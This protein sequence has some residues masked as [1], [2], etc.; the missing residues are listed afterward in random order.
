MSKLKKI[1][2]LIQKAA[3]VVAV[4]VTAD[5]AVKI[6]FAASD[7]SSYSDDRSL[8]VIALTILTLYLYKKNEP[9]NS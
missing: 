1:L 6:L 4:A 3:L 5:L 8:Y 9:T 2:Q 7:V